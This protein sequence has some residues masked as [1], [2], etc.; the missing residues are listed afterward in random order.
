LIAGLHKKALYGL[1]CDYYAIAVE[2]I[3][4]VEI[5]STGFLDDVCSEEGRRGV[6]DEGTRRSPGDKS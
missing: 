1:G 3:K 2:I 6:L 5:L 4:E